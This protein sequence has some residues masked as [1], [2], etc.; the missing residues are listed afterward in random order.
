MN[1]DF[2]NALHEEFEHFAALLLAHS[3]A[4]FAG[5]N[6]PKMSALDGNDPFVEFD[7]AMFDDY[8]QNYLTAGM[9]RAIDS[10]VCYRN[11]DEYW[12]WKERIPRRN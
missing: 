11:L 3:P 10:E 7:E 8:W 1:E 4:I 12:Q 9:A 5:E 6:R 2:L